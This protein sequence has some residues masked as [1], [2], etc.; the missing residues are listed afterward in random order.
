MISQGTA[1]KADISLDLPG[2]YDGQVITRFPPEPSGYLHIGHSK[3]ALLNR[4]FADK[5]HG[6]M[7]LRFDDTN[8]LKE[9]SEFEESITEDLA[10]LGIKADAISHTSDWFDE[11][12]KLAIQLIKSGHAYC[13][14][15]PQMQMRDERMKGIASG[16]RESS[17]EDSLKRFDEMTLGTDEG[18]RWCLRAKMSVDDPNK[19]M[20]DTVIYRC[21]KEAH[22]RTG[23]KYF[24]YPTYDFA[25]PVVDSLEGVTH[26]LRTN[27]YRDRNPQYFWFIDALNLRAPHIWDFSCV[28]RLMARIDRPSESIG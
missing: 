1:K 14:D 17:V 19:A 25:C 8:P 13:D 16:R 15:T 5:Y 23:T 11:L 6:K 27:E 12:H 24:S 21:V 2:A 22:H 10:L 9:K 28:S 20:R 7:L 3:A 18:T 26:A 4:F